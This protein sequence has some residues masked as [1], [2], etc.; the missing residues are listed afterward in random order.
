MSN[1]DAPS[2]STLFELQRQAIEQGRQAFE[3]I[4]EVQLRFNEAAVSG[5]E[6]TGEMYIES[7][8]T[9]RQAM[10]SYADALET[11]LPES[12]ETVT[13]MRESI[14]EGFDQLEDRQAELIE[15]IEDRAGDTKEFSEAYLDALDDQLD[16]LVDT[17]E[18]V[19]ERTVQSLDEIESQVTQIQQSGEEQF[20]EQAEMLAE[21]VSNLQDRMQPAAGD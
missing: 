8:E 20:S 15:R 5:A 14:D 4:V 21:R 19:E 6:A 3:G 10:H 1:D 13:Q 11:V 9:R 17:H 7:L 18:T 2:L 12:S 16:V